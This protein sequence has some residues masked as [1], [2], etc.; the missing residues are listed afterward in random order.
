MACRMNSRKVNRKKTALPKATTFNKVVSI[1]LKVHNDSTYVLWCVDEATKLIRG[2]VIHDKTP[3]MIIK[4]LK[5]IWI[6]GGGIGP[7]MPARYFMSDN[8]REF[9]N[10]KFTELL[11]A[12]EISL[13]TTPAY[14]L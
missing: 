7:G 12:Y 10:S 9:C 5:E 4:A 1:D 14:S 6:N 8:G 13:Q 2:R 11:Q 3:E